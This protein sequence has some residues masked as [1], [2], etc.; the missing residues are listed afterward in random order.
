MRNLTDWK[1][2]KYVSYSRVVHE[3]KNYKLHAILIIQQGF[4]CAFNSTTKFTEKF[5]KA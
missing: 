2:N 1:G 4:L 5:P 3:K